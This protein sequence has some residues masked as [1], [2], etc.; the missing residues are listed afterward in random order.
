MFAFGP[1]AQDFAGVQDNTDIAK[2]IAK[3]TNL[4][5]FPVAVD[6]P[7]KNHKKKADAITAP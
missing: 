2:K 3:L 6:V 1:G 7:A 4:S 5:P